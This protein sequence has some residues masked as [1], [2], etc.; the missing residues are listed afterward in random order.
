MSAGPGQRERAGKWVLIL[1]EEPFIQDTLKLNLAGRGL[2]AELA[3]NEA[4]A[5][6]L[7]GQGLRPACII[8]DVLHSRL[9]AYRFLQWLK[10]E[11]DLEKIPVV[12]LTFKEK[13]PETAF[14]YNVWARAYLHKPFVPQ[15]VVNLVARLA[16]ESGPES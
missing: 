9:N 1:E 12:I 15:E 13:D 16:A 3:E 11:P 14:T 2:G 4:E 10:N 6:R 7:L 8:L 5:R